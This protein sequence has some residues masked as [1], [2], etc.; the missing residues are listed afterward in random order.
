MLIK[1]KHSIL[2][3]EAAPILNY[4]TRV[5]RAGPDFKMQ[6]GRDHR[7][8]SFMLLKHSDVSSFS[9][10]VLR[11]SQETKYLQYANDL[12]EV[13]SDQKLEFNQHNTTNRFYRRKL[14]SSVVP[15]EDILQENMNWLQRQ[16]NG[17]TKTAQNFYPRET[18]WSEKKPVSESRLPELAQ[19]ASLA[20]LPE[21]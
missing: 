5:E 1:P 19:T 20:F 13:D 3:L 14:R 6:L 8:H 7:P 17:G 9:I 12:D 15:I 21:K 18:E 2:K 16:H 4:E 10:W 11:T